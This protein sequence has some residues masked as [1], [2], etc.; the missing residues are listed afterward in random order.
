MLNLIIFYAEDKLNIVKKLRNIN[1][2]KSMVFSFTMGDCSLLDCI[3]CN[4]YCI[5]YT[6]VFIFHYLLGDKFGRLGRNNVLY[7]RRT[8][9][10]GVG[11]LL[12]PH[13]GE[14]IFQSL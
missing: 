11:L 4:I 1:A 12:S 14:Y 5:L 13:C 9:L 2:R 10:L 3:Y 8:F 6:L 7:S